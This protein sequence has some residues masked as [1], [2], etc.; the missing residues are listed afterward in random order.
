MKRLTLFLLVTLMCLEI[1]SNDESVRA[2]IDDAVELINSRLSHSRIVA[3]DARGVVQ[4]QA[5]GQRIEFPVQKVSFHYNDSNHRVRVAGDFNIRHYDEE[6]ELEEVTHRQSFSCHSRRMAEDAV[7]AFRRIKDIFIEETADEPFLGLSLPRGP[8][9]LSFRTLR[10]AVRFVNDSLSLSLIVDVSEN[11]NMII[12]SP[13]AMYLVDLKAADFALNNLTNEPRLRIYGYWCVE[14]YEPG[15]RQRGR[16]IPRESFSFHSSERAR[17]CVRAL[18]YIKGALLGQ[19][20]EQIELEPNITEDVLEEYKSVE[21]AIRYLNNRLKISIV[22]GIDPEGRLVVNAS[23]NIYKIPLRNCVFRAGRNGLT[24]FGIGVFGSRNDAVEV[25]CSRELE[26]YA[27]K[28][29]VKRSKEE[30]FSVTSRQ[31]IDEVVAALE[32]IQNKIR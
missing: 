23:E 32:Y 26:I 1:H 11:G 5:P 10:E 3:V 14:T 22:T 24:F 7:E 18:Y 20:A 9:P 29:L 21:E 12:N 17:Q 4:V 2:R 19:T 6:G 15:E 16:F 13:G 28:K 25:R 27:D 8:V 31:G 30:R